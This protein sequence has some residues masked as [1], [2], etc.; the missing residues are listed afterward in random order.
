MPFSATIGHHR[1][2]FD[3]VRESLAKATPRRS[4]DASADGLSALA[5]ECHARLLLAGFLPQLV[6]CKTGPICI[7][8]QG[9]VQI[10]DEIGFLLRSQLSVVLTGERPRL[11]SPHSLGAYITWHPRPGRTDAARNP[12][13][14]IRAEGLSY[15]E[16][17]KQLV[18]CVMAAHACQ[19]T[20]TVLG[21]AKSVL[22]G[23]GNNGGQP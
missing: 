2:T 4:G 12:I 13:S 22:P 7:V 9:R 23:S 15:G 1:Y 3:S 8:E 20:G 16:A 11:S 18:D 19:L 14:N 17:A 6:A 21:G 5:V 10:G